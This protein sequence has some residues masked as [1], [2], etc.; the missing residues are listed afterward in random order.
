VRARPAQQAAT[1]LLAEIE[2]RT[3]DADGAAA[4]LVA[5][6]GETSPDSV[7]GVLALRAR[8]ALAEEG[9]AAHLRA[10]AE[11]LSAPGLSA[12]ML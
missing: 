7:V 3:G 6:I 5:E 9:A 12:G 4:E 8:A 1:A 2:A 11:E 10:A